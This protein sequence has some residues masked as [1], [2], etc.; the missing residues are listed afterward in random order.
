MQN[1]KIKTLQVLLISFRL[2]TFSFEAKLYVNK[3]QGRLQD[4]SRLVD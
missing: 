4:F 1:A 2:K 3:A